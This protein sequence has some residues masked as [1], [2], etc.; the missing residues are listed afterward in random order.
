MPETTVNQRTQQMMSPKE[1]VLK[2]RIDRR[3]EEIKNL[4]SK[5]RHFRWILFAVMVFCLGVIFIMPRIHSLESR[6]SSDYAWLVLAISIIIWYSSH[7]LK[8]VRAWENAA[9]FRFGKLLKVNTESLSGRK[10]VQKFNPVR[11]WY[12]FKDKVLWRRKDRVRKPGPRWVWYFLDKI[13]F[14]R[15]DQREGLPLVLSLLCQDNID[16]DIKVFFIFRVKDVAS[17]LVNISRAIEALTNMVEAEIRSFVGITTFDELRGPKKDEFSKKLVEEINKQIN[18]LIPEDPDKNDSL[19]VI[20]KDKDWGIELVQIR[21]KDID[22]KPD[23]LEKIQNVLKAK[24]DQ[25]VVIIN[26][27]AKKAEIETLAEAEKTKVQKA[28]EAKR[29]ELEQQA[30]GQGA[31]IAK[32]GKAYAEPGGERVYG[33]EISK[34]IKAGDKTIIMSLGGTQDEAL[35]SKAFGALAGGMSVLKGNRKE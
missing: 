7:C 12:F 5:F 14:I 4:V 2:D 32:Q 9:V 23:V 19:L 34:T 10:H 3:V 17:F 15:T 20:D 8:F 28:A 25:E 1:D 11:L 13:V 16:V 24:K 35:L 31:F 18:P 33:V 6:T 26:A 27:N 21:M 30:E 29:F 22:P